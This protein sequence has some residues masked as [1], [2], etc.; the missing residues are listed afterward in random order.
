MGSLSAPSASTVVNGTTPIT[1]AGINRVLFA[2]TSQKVSTDSNFT[3]V[4]ANKNLNFANAANTLQVGLISAYGFEG[5]QC[6]GGQ[7]II[8]GTQAAPSSVFINA[9][10]A[11]GSIVLC[12]ANTTVLTIGA[13][14]VNTAS[15]A[16][17]RAGSFTVA[18]LPAAATAGV[19]GMATVTDALAPAFGAAVAAGGAIVTP[20]YSTGIVWNVG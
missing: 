2:D 9:S 13:S 10:S 5:I 15:S 16:T 17:L 4:A 14:S 18:T 8:E 1:G 3:Y 12:N 11:S 19:G 20:V 6:V 7:F